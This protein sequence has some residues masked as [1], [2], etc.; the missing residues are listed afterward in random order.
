[1]NVN[2]ARGAGCVTQIYDGDGIA[3]ISTQLPKGSAVAVVYE[4]DDCGGEYMRK[5]R[6]AGMAPRPARAGDSDAQVTATVVDDDVR[7]IV[8]VG[9]ET[10]ADFAKRLAY[11]RGLPLYVAVASP[12]AMTVLDGYCLM[13]EGDVYAL[14]KGAAPVGAA[15]LGDEAEKHAFDLPAAFGGICAVA[16]DMFDREAYLRATGKP[17]RPE[18]RDEAFSLVYSA[19]DAA[20]RGRDSAGLASSFAGISLKMALLSQSAG[21]GFI[22][23]ASDDCAR[24]ATMLLRR[25]KRAAMKRGE[26]AFI[27]GTVLSKAYREF[28][29]VPSAFTPPPDNNLRAELLSEYFG[30]DE[31]TAARAAVSKLK[32]SALALY[33]VHE[34]R[35]ELREVASDAVKVFDE[36]KKLFRRMYDDDGYSLCG[37]LDKSDVR[38][39]VALAPDTFAVNG[40]ALMLMREFGLLDRYL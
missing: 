11:K 21:S 5:L 15:V 39:V 17:C 7:A 2:I 8:A 30:Y 33:R 6:R 12:S 9:G 1:M 40:S 4:Q 32:S 16:A 10:S 35:D 24:T 23:S 38:T 3:E 25:E 20:S 19:I 28:A 22:R 18:V 34:Y 31:I 29:C 36:S 26:L 14:R 27:F 13:R 37:K